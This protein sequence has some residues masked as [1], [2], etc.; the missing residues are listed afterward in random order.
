MVEL[1]SRTTGL[2]SWLIPCSVRASAAVS[3]A[4]RTAPSS[5]SVSMA[6]TSFSRATMYAFMSPTV[7]SAH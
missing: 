1:S 7:A 6:R 3:L 4:P 5:A 2:S